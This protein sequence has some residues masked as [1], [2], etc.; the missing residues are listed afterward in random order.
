MRRLTVFLVA[1]GT[2][3]AFPRVSAQGPNP[4]T[5]PPAS[6][7]HVTLQESPQ[8]AIRWGPPCG[9]NGEEIVRC[10][11]FTISVENGSKATVR[12]DNSCSEH[13]FSIWIKAPT[14]SGEWLR[15]DS[16]GFPC[17]KGSR[18]KD[19]Q[20]PG[21]RLSPGE[22]FS[23]NS[24]VM[25]IG[26][27]EHA[28]YTVRA[29][30]ALR[31]CV[32]FPDH[33]DC[34]STLQAMPTTPASVPEVQFSEPVTVVSNEIIVESPNLPDLGEMKFGLQVEIDTAAPIDIGTRGGCTPRNAAHLACT[35]FRYTIRNLG[36]RPVLNVVTNCNGGSTTPDIAA[37]YRVPSGEWKGFPIRNGVCISTFSGLT[38]IPVGGAAE[39]EFTLATLGP[40]LSARPLE[41]PGKYQLRFEFSPHACFATP[42]GRSCATV[43]LHPPSVVSHELTVE[44]R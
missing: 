43:L 21:I 44:V 14:A 7:F 2:A 11:T 38:A 34:L 12:L 41:A 28:P 32:E 30:M 39:A 25:A 17:H 8:T 36:D 20:P 24:G 19:S 4:D 42:E 37:E 23:L 1:C 26:S 33:A 5:L 22:S 15:R 40:G 29:S 13:M 18:L 10:H 16:F 27:A 35:T 9:R 3:L 6:A 31:D